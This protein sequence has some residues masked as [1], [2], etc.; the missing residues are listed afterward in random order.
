M[1]SAIFR[2]LLLQRIERRA[3]SKIQQQI[4]GGQAYNV[5]N[6]AN[7]LGMGNSFQKI[8]DTRESIGQPQQ[9]MK[10]GSSQIHIHCHGRVP[11]L[12]QGN[13]QICSQEGFANSAF[14]E[15][16]GII[17]TLSAIEIRFFFTLQ[18]QL[19]FQSQRVFPVLPIY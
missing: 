13:S 11:H 16:I 15:A 9:G 4:L 18:C 3:S 14:P 5:G 12:S 7:F 17:V 1:R 2:M 8:P 10:I 6:Q 19:V